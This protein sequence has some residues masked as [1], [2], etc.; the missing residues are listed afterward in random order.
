MTPA[1]QQQSQLHHHASCLPKP[2]A[3][4]SLLAAG[5][6]LRT[7]CGT[8]DISLPNHT[9]LLRL[10]FCPQLA[11]SWPR[12]FSM[13]PCPWLVATWA[14]WGTSV[15]LLASAWVPTQR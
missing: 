15:W 12:W 3:D 11:S 2:L 10:M 1:K 4:E 7:G 13:C 5:A 9:C 8:V 6:V 14:M